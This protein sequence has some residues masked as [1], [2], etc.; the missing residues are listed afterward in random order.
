MIPDLCRLPVVLSIM[1]VIEL[2]LIVH[3]LGLGSFKSFAWADFALLSFYT[4]WIALPSVWLLCRLRQRLNTL[5]APAIT[6]LTVMITLV[7]TGL[8]NAIF[9]GFSEIQSEQLLR[10]M[11]IVA[12]I[13]CLG[14]RY[15]FVQQRWLE[16]QRA[17]E[18]ARFSALQSRIQPHFLFNTLNSISSLVQFDVEKAERAIQDMSNLLRQQID[19][20]QRFVPWK[21]ERELCEAYLRIETL[22]YGNRLLVEWNIRAVPDDF[23]IVPL[24]IQ[25][26]LE[27]AIRYG[28]AP[29]AESA[30]IIVNA[31]LIDENGETEKLV[32]SIE[33]PVS[34]EF[35]PYAHESIVPHSELNQGNGIALSNV[36]ARIRSMYRDPVTGEEYASLK[37]EQPSGKYR[38]VLTFA[39]NLPESLAV[40]GVGY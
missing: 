23:K 22:R 32:I 38:V 37:V 3:L 17:K 29:S 18:S 5:S 27:N 10:D 39:L 36:R 8:A 13:T 31:K 12:V 6:L 24:T 16:E 14:L 19:V 7:I 33:N 35:R 9:A 28:I 21:A 30:T 40:S 4:Q 20:D 26:L 15:C 11:T 34:T 2:L 1:V 25:P